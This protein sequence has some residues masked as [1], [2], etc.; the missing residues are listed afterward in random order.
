MLICHTCGQRP[1]AGL[2]V[3]LS[4]CHR[5]AKEIISPLRCHKDESPEMVIT[6]CEKRPLPSNGRHG[7]L[8]DRRGPL[9]S[10]LSLEAAAPHPAFH[11]AANVHTELKAS[12][13]GA[14]VLAPLQNSAAFVVTG[15]GWLLNF[16]DLLGL[17]SENTLR[18]QQGWCCV[19]GR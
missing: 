19:P 13:K 1:L 7:G 17:E 12:I 3:G 6:L 4:D 10:S 9:N 14:D 5:V 18:S 15:A 16:A 11:H 8:G 2:R